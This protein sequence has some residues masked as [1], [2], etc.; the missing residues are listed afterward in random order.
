[1]VGIVAVDDVKFGLVWRSFTRKGICT[2]EYLKS[3]LLFFVSMYCI[4][5]CRP[6]SVSGCVDTN[7]FVLSM[8]SRSSSFPE[9]FSEK[10]YT[11]T[12]NIS[13]GNCGFLD[14]RLGN[15]ES[16]DVSAYVLFIAY[17]YGVSEWG[18]IKTAAVGP[19]IGVIDSNRGMAIAATLFVSKGVACSRK[20]LS[21]RGGVVMVFWTLQKT[22]I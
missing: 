21:C 14:T 9:Y 15:T 18:I 13:D 20:R 19:T 22:N 10:S 17:V 11:N 7:S 12:H 1:M 6:S 5:L 16:K 3:L 4:K 8:E 2:L